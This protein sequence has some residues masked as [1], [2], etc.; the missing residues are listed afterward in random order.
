MDTKTINAATNPDLANKLVEQAV[1]SAQE[2]ETPTPVEILYPPKLTVELPGGY[3]TPTG[4]LIREATVRELTGRDEEAISRADTVGKSLLLILQRGTVSIGEEPATEELLDQLLIADR[5]SLLLGIYKATFGTTVEMTAWFDGTPKQV[6]IDLDEE[7]HTKMM[8]DPI[9]DR[10]FTVTYRNREFLV[11][12]P[13]G[14]LQKEMFKNSDKAVAELSTLLLENT[15]ISIDGE[16]VY[17]KSQVQDLGLAHRTKIISEISKRNAGPQFDP[18][19]VTDPESGLE[20]VIPI[21]L[22]TLFR[23]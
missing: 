15:I 22:G 5:E 3:I 10:E 19:K 4:E 14:M 18:V 21:S 1:A 11:T 12:L 6:E 16:R 2:T 23:L 8:N 20:A 9:G 17:K 7:I 13:T